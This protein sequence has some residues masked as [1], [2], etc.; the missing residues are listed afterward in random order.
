[1]KIR[2][3]FLSLLLVWASFSAAETLVVEDFDYAVST[4]L[5]SCG[6][7]ML[8]YGGDSH[9]SITSGLEFYG[10]EGCGVGGA[11]LL[12][13]KFSNDQPHLPFTKVES[14]TVYVA[15][16]LQPSI[17]YKK[18]YFFCL[19]DDK[20]NM[21][22]FNFNARVSL[23]EDYHLG[24][25]FADNQKAVYMN[26]SLDYQSVYLVVI[27]YVIN[28]FANNDEASLY[29]FNPGAKKGDVLPFETEPAEPTIGPLT[30]SSKTDIKPANLVLR[31]FDADGWVVVDG[32]RVATSWE[33]AVKVNKTSD[34]GLLSAVDDAQED[35]AI[36]AVYDLL[37]NFVG[38]SLD[39]LA[40]DRIYIVRSKM[41]T[42]CIRCCTSVGAD[43]S[44]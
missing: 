6:S 8:Q 36:I 31:G 40:S 5:T 13:G 26:Q 30:D 39:G 38:A 15:F 29:V 17:V 3:L 37:G 32:I 43:A 21:S 7:W 1:M 41:G 23:D 28:E 42:R 24:F 18:G 33:E 20:I 25:T 10:Y 35:D 12:D 9:Y 34:C 4:P 2:S 44:R 11:A 14:G 16:L 27:K 22:E 19:R